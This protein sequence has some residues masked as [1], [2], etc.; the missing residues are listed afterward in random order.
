MSQPRKW[1]AYKTLTISPRHSAQI[2]CIGLTKYSKRCRWD[3]S[4][5]L[6]PTIHS[7][8]TELESQ[9]PDP[10]SL[11][12]ILEQLAPL[13][14]CNDFHQYQA[15][16]VIARWKG[17][18]EDVSEEWRSSQ[19]ERE[20]L[21]GRLR[22]ESEKA[23]ELRGRV[24]ELMG[25]LVRERERCGQ[26]VERCS[27][28]ESVKE[29]LLVLVNRHQKSLAKSGRE[30][31]RLERALVLLK[32][33]M[34]G[35]LGQEKRG[36]EEERRKAGEEM[37]G[38]MKVLLESREKLEEQCRVSKQLLESLEDVRATRAKSV[39]EMEALKTQLS[40]ERE[41]LARQR[42]DLNDANRSKAELFA[43]IDILSAQLSTA[44]Q[45]C[46][47]LKGTLSEAANTQASLAKDQET[48]RSQ[49][50]AEQQ[51]T[52]QL[53]AELT[54][55][56]N[57][58][59]TSQQAHTDLTTQFSTHASEVAKLRERISELESEV[60]RS[61]LRKFMV[62]IRTMGKGFGDS[63]GVPGRKRLVVGVV[64]R[65]K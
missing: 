57:D 23:E 40:V 59:Q 10:N 7:L 44:Q 34:E 17:A 42:N 35:L 1:D 48:I 47:E 52:A 18:I 15:R 50:A 39:E 9:P 41:E 33:E 2:S 19:E 38:Q 21:E 62:R 6:L 12:R 54:K 20:A 64:E 36:R 53:Q 56:Q 26:W 29:R 31:E 3:I 22:E 11:A 51:T 55:T 46:S 37:E 27:E 5:S 14:L 43:Q 25:E 63:I 58:L 60:T 49:L 30:V 32:G 24:E 16:Q 61:W 8:L 28:A 65:G 13:C 45:E 4:P